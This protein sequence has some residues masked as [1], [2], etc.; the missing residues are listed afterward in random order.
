MEK[1]KELRQKL[2]ELTAQAR[3]INDKVVEESR[4]YTSEEEQEWQRINDEITN[5]ELK[6]TDLEKAEERQRSIE[7]REGYLKGREREPIKPDPSDS[8]KGERNDNPFKS[9][10]YRAAFARY[11][12]EGE[13]L[14]ESEQ[15]ALSMGTGAEGG[16]TVDQEVFLP[17][18][19]K[20]V[21]D[22][23]PT[24]GL[25]R[26]IQLTE[27]ASLGAPVLSNDPADADW[28]TEL[29]TGNLDTTMDFAKRSLTPNP[30]AKRIKVSKK[31]LRASSLNIAALV[32]QRLGYKLGIT[33]EKAFMTGSGS[34]QPLG[35]FTADANGI[36]T[37]RDTDVGDGS[38]GI[39]ADK[40][41]DLRHA[42]RE[43][44]NLRWQFHRLVLAAVRKLKDANNQYLWAPGL[45]GGIP[46][47]LLDV[48]Y[49]LNENAPSTIG[50]GS[51]VLIIG[52]WSY[53]WIVEALNMELQTLV[54][55]YAE[56]NQNGYIIR[57]EIDAMPVLEDAFRRGKINA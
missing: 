14:G 49:T 13:R 21:D 30:L 7:E 12:V 10:E 55:L 35:V 32:A 46:G 5:I 29:A 41:I 25:A 18:L 45:A 44:Y 42:M 26:V 22:L 54:E 4:A 27:A 50:A 19:I 56:A 39:S 9:P 1:L 23:A 36:S 8:P 6:I 34:A 37:A 57:A 40:V 2:G 52:D 16:F 53:Y 48:P 33:E 43:G 15:R 51:Y 28:T 38:G 47:T 20:S 17:E 24:R 3:A 11:L 31:L